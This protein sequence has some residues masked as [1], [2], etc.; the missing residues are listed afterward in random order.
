MRAESHA[1]DDIIGLP[2]HRSATHPPMSNHDRAAQFSPFA[3][4]TG[5]GEAVEETARRTEERSEI[6]E[7]RA[8]RLDEKLRLLLARQAARPVAEV[9]YFEPDERKAGGAYVKVTG[10]VR[11]VDT[12]R[13]LLCFT[14]GK[15]ISFDDIYD[16]QGE[17]LSDRDQEP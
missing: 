15:R 1:Y 17:G 11:R 14:D 16:I 4:L 8:A 2:H 9:T 12:Q 5:Y 7:S 3:A 10:K 13:R 6:G